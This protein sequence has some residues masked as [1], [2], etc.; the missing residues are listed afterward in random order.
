MALKGLSEVNRNLNA[1]LKRVRGKSLEGLFDAGLIVQKAAQ[2]KVPVEYGNLR[3]SAYTRKS[4]GN[5]NSVVVGF[6][7]EYAFKVHEDLEPTLKGKPRPSGLGDYWGPSGEPR[8]LARAIDE[9]LDTI[10]KVV[11]RKARVT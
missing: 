4:Q 8:F 5:P 1:K 9:N 11:K 6:E 3:A 2:K 7:A 10:V